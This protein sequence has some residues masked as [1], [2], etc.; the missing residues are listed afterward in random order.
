MNE[1]SVYLDPSLTK[2]DIE[3]SGFDHKEY[4]GLHR[5]FNG[6]NYIFIGNLNDKELKKLMTFVEMCPIGHLFEVYCNHEK[7]W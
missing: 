6:S 3:F 1:V 4:R 7:I 2:E 5:C